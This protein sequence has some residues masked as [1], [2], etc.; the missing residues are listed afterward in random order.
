MAKWR[1]VV[2]ALGLGIAG[3]VIATILG[4]WLWRLLQGK[5]EVQ[6]ASVMPPQRAVERN[7]PVPFGPEVLAEA[8]PPPSATGM[9]SAVERLAVR[10][11][12]LTLI[13]GIG[14]RYA[15]GLARL[16]VTTFARLSQ[17]N[18]DELTAR[19][20]AQGLRIIGDRIR[21]EDW[22]GQAARLARGQKN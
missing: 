8:S 11:D 18:P 17:Q 5:Q 1:R 9:G 10:P 2:L 16:G 12:D 7:I 14:P 4:W 6:E 20:K 13:S 19:L 22:I 3:A 15:E 21:Q